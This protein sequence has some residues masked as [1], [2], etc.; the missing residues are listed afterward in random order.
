M[1]NNCI[2]TKNFENTSTIYSANKLV[3]VFMVNDAKYVIDR[4]F[5]TLL[6]RFQ[7]KHQMKM[8]ANLLM[9]VLLYCIIIFRK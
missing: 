4:L 8:E 7:Q 5:D 6:Q 2:S 3:D 1:Q 9:K